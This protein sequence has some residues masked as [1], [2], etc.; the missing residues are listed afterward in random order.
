MVWLIG[1]AVVVGLVVLKSGASSGSGGGASGVSGAGGGG[2]DGGA[3][4]LDSLSQGFVD[5]VEEVRA[6]EAADA[7]WKQGIEAAIQTGAPTNPNP[8]P[9]PTPTTPKVTA[10]FG[11]TIV[12][13][14]KNT[15]TP[16]SLAAA[17]K[18]AGVTSWGK[19]I[20]VT[21]LQKALKKE[22]INY[23]SVVDN[24][25]LAQLFKKTGVKPVKPQPPAS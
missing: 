16:T 18:K 5:L 14:I 21:D 25:D 3:D 12:S 2:G 20:D 22:G 19:T 8:A 11:S 7:L 1:G 13:A 4:T 23:G 24:K 17:M 6:Q 10:K 9:G 15:Y